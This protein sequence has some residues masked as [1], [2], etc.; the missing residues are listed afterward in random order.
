MNDLN[1]DAL[2]CIYTAHLHHIS[3]EGSIQ[4]D[5][6]KKSCLFHKTSVWPS[7]FPRIFPV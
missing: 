4:S 5:I 2:K 3:I 6:I 1:Y 7:F